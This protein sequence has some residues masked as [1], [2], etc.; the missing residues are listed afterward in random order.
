VTAGTGSGGPTGGAPVAGWDLGHLRAG[1]AVVGL[2]AAVG[3]PLTWWLRGGR[4]ALWALAGLAIVAAFFTVGTLAVVA[5]GRIN[6]EY[7]LGAALGSY[8][9]KVVL[10]GVLLVTARDQSWVDG[11]ALAWAVLAGTLAWVGT[12]IHRVFTSRIYYV[13]P[14]PP[15]RS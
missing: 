6:D 2:L 4:G 12:H 15:G 5:A 14:H 7:T 10:L 8:L 1:L 11:P 3:G 9:V 13:D